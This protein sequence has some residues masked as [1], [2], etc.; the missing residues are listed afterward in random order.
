MLEATHS[1]DLRWPKPGWWVV[2][3]P[4]RGGTGRYSEAALAPCFLSVESIGIYRVISLHPVRRGQHELPVP[5]S[6][7]K[8]P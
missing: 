8:G 3:P 5:T 2:G 6:D 4:L 1:R 7:A